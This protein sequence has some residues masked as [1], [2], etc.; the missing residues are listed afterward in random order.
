MNGE[1]LKLLMLGRLVAFMLLFYLGFGLLVEWKSVR[2]GSKLKGFS[3]LLCKPLT[4]PI[5]MLSPEGTP[6]VTI[7]RRTALAAVAVWLFFVI[8]SESALPGS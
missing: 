8:A 3:R 1:L 7:L 5:A 6:Y 2:E 4:A